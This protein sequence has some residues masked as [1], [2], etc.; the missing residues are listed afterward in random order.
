L[1]EGAIRFGFALV[2]LGIG[3]TVL[4]GLSHWRTLR[5]LNRNELPVLTMWPL[6]ITV[7]MLLAIAGLAAVWTLLA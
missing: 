3:A 2:L 5:S 4:A 7:A 1:H 6:S